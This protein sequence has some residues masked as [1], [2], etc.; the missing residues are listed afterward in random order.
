MPA[1]CTMR[2]TV[3]VRLA[4]LPGLIAGFVLWGIK[5]DCGRGAKVGEDTTVGLGSAEV[6][7]VPL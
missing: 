3:A 7:V 2:G 1:A 6:C 4:C 5:G